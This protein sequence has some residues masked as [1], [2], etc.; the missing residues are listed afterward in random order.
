MVEQ[1]RRR[2]STTVRR[3][4]RDVLVSYEARSRTSAALR[5]TVVADG[6]GAAG[7]DPAGWSGPL[8]TAEAGGIAFVYWRAPGDDV[9][10]APPPLP[11]AI[12]AM[13]APRRGFRTTF[14]VP[15]HTSLPSLVENAVDRAHFGAVH[16]RRVVDASPYRI[17]ARDDGSFYARVRLDTKVV[18]G[19]RT[20]SI[21]EVDFADPFNSR[22]R[23]KYFGQWFDLVVLTAP[24]GGR[25]VEVRFV[26]LSPRW[27]PVLD[28]VIHYSMAMSERWL[29][30]DDD[31]VL[32]TRTI[33]PRPILSDVD[34]PILAIRRWLAGHRAPDLDDTHDIDDR[35]RR[36]TGPAAPATQRSLVR[37]EGAPS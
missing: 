21:T 34:G 20:L 22:I 2:G 37:S 27:I 4:D 25:V 24:K 17:Q 12:P 33:A 36:S 29:I 9:E 13:L 11:P 19:V 30:L 8:P 23:N 32:A 16:G 3:F 26:V 31:E 7:A 5:A 15:V 1:L 35:H 28:A 14:T 18:P 6:S 10:A